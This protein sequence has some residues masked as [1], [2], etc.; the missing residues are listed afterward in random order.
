VLW[1]LKLQIL[2]IAI[3]P[4]VFAS[5]LENITV[6]EYDSKNYY[7]PSVIQDQGYSSITL[8]NLGNA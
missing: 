3:S 8:V 1:T 2:D 4:L 7:L 6:E 5:P